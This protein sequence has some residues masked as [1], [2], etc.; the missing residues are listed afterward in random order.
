MK[1]HLVLAGG[2]H[3]HMMT[4]AHLH[5]F[6]EKGHQVTVIQPSAYHYYS[7]MG[8]G[9]LGRQYRPEEIR[10]AT[11]RVVEKKGGRF[12]LGKIAGADPAAGTVRLES[13]ESLPFD[14]IS[15]NVGSHV[16][17]SHIVG[18]GTDI[19]PVKPI[20][21]LLQA[22]QRILELASQKKITVGVIGGGP[23]AVEIAGNIWR[24]ARGNTNHRPAIIICTRKR[25]MPDH[26]QGIR[27]KAL[28]SLTSRGVT[29]L[30]ESAV[31]EIATGRI[32]LES[33]QEHAM[34]IVFVALGVKPSPVFKDSGLPTG[35]DGG[36]LVNRYLQSPAHPNLFGGGDCIYFQEQPLNKVGVYAV[37]QNPVLLHNLMAALEGQALQ[38]FAPGGDYLLI[39]NL[40]D[41]TGIFR[42]GRL[43]FGGRPAF[44]IK[45]YIDRKFMRKFQAIE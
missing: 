12:V 15:F 18:D 4:L 13:G 41:G 31:K 8:P 21:K 26:P 34:D 24:L 10:F 23:S 42:K 38:P 44:I 25:L 11:R 20:E 19:F 33:R 22:Q 2:G 28:A 1:K 40:G 17:Q 37:R 3:A 45:D 14:V 7:G 36:L 9:M 39:F 35:P 32:R 29:V 5:Q 16:P 43:Q 6:V 30:E 27:T